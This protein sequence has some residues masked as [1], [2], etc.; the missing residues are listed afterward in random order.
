ME[1]QGLG[2]V[3]GFDQLTRGPEYQILLYSVV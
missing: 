1:L 3:G 2:N